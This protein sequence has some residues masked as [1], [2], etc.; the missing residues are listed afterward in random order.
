MDSVTLALLNDFCDS[1]G[2]NELT[3]DKKFEHFAAYSVVSS[4]YSED[5]DTSDLVAGDGQDL[6]V[7]AFA[8]K[9]N[10]RLANDPDYID[11]VLALNGSLD[12]EFI[13]IQAK[14]SSSFDGAAIIALGDNL[15]NEVFSETQSLPFNDDIKRLIE[16]KDR[17]FRNASRLRD[18][19]VCRVYYVCTGNW[20]EDVYLVKAIKRKRQDLL[21][22]NL[23]SEVFFEPI[24]ARSLQA[25][26]RAT[27]TI[28]S[29][30][31][32]FD[33]LVTLPAISEVSASYL[34]VLPVVEFLKLL[35]DDSGDIIKSVFVDN[36]RDFQGENPV[37]I[38]IAKTITDGLFDQFVLR[39]NG[40]TIVARNIRVVSN[41]YILE[42]FQIVNGCQTS[43]VIFANRSKI[44]SD[45]F[46]PI[47]LIHTTSEDVAQS[48]IKSTN[49]QT[50]VEENDLL[51]LTQFQRDLEDYY[52]GVQGDN[53][54]YYERRA[55]QY[56]GETGIEKGRIISIGNQLK[57]Y[58]SMFLDYPNQASRYQGTLLKTVKDPVFQAHHKPEPYF[59]SALALYRFEVAIRR[60]A[61]EERGIR[62]FKYF[63]LFAYRCR[64]E[65]TDFPGASNK[66][67]ASYCDSLKNS[68]S[69]ANQSK[70]AFDECVLIVKEA[71]EALSLPLERDSAKSRPLIDEVRK[72]AANKNVAK[73]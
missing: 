23:F 70:V 43:H 36:V 32:K 34:G 39:N 35:T 66:R 47:K 37:N 17:I 12:A 41:Q 40:I 68:L 72:I 24:G 18:N 1:S 19:P 29:R 48:V 56:A 46:I 38:D 30:E 44:T 15:A 65:T 25:M 3:M 9:V 59:V 27:K 21:D 54:L 71:L 8:V 62:P 31:I 20:I 6:N 51:A 11:D 49:K 2:L 61:T 57:S 53:K 10:G 42:D 5:F 63:L 60:L 28:I 13:I 58:A 14:S 4:R 16:I 45:L 52:S 33:K 55:K 22:T 64:F 7:D 69:D 67:I 50:N 26:F 73:V